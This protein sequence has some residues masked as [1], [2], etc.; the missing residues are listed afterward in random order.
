MSD[1]KIQSEILDTGIPERKAA[2]IIIDASPSVI[3]SIL[4]S[5]GR[6]KEIDGSSTITANI[7]GPTKLELGSKFGMKMH[8]GINYRIT[9]TVVEYRENELIAWRH[10]GRWVWR[11]ELKLIGPNKTQVTETFDASRTPVLSRSWLKM[12]NAYPWVQLSVAKTLVRLK[13]VAESA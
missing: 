10:L 13:A 11:Y 4:N 3:F 7:S 9:N 12:R 6:H 1:G 8:L 2:R 5:P